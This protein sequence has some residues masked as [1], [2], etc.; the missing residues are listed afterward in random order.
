MKRMLVLLAITLLSLFVISCSNDEQLEQ[1]NTLIMQ[2]VNET[3]NKT[4]EKACPK[5][6][7]E[8]EGC[9]I[10]DEFLENCQ[11][12][13]ILNTTGGYCRKIELS[14][15]PEICEQKF[16][17]LENLLLSQ[18][19]IQMNYGGGCSI[20]FF[21]TYVISL[22]DYTYNSPTNR[23]DVEAGDAIDYMKVDKNGTG[24]H[25]LHR[26]IYVDDDNIITESDSTCLRDIVSRDSFFTKRKK[27]IVLRDD[28]P[29]LAFFQNPHFDCSFDKVDYMNT[30]FNFS[31]LLEL[32]NERKKRYEKI[33]LPDCW[34]VKLKPELLDHSLLTQYKEKAILS[35]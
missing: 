8:V 28:V 18:K 33:K 12:L 13:L 7:Q 21:A 20:R 1:N 32:C 9:E 34:T 23:I 27:I 24:Y 19:N 4:P 26:V 35:E 14:S 11:H 22:T 29:N 5:E 6:I 25:F 30:G 17:E 10:L 3:I 31:K 2:E 15:L 16:Y